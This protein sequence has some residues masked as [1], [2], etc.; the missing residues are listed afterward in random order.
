M[1]E[2]RFFLGLRQFQ[3]TAAKVVGVH[4]GK[5]SRPDVGLRR[6]FYS[7]TARGA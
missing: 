3:R 4:G 1:R 2:V 6:R 5:T 7:A